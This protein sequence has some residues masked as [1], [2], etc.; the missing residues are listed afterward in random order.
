MRV[1]LS[2]GYNM[3]FQMAQLLFSVYIDKIYN[4]S[5]KTVLKSLFWS[6]SAEKF[7]TTQ[8]ALVFKIY[9]S[10]VWLWNFT[11]VFVGR[12]MN[13]FG[14]RLEKCQPILNHLYKYWNF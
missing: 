5:F 12:G 7:P 6:F 2:T 10:L 13:H 1:E 11:F 3:N 8:K 4:I 9:S 14:V